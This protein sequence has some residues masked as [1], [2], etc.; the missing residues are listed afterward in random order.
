MKR[1]H[2]LRK[3]TSLLLTT[4]LAVSVL[5]AAAAF[6]SSAAEVQMQTFG[7]ISEYEDFYQE[8][9]ELIDRIALGIYNMDASISVRDLT[10]PYPDTDIGKVLTIVNRIHPELFY[11]SG[12]S[13]T[14]YSSGGAKYLG[15][16]RP[17]YLY[18]NDEIAAMREEFYSRAQWFIDKVD[19][20]MSD[21]D[22]ALLLHDELALYGSYLLSGETYS[23]MVE[24]KGKCYGYSEVYAFL[25]A[26][27]GIKSEIIE[28]SAMN[29]QWNKVCIDGVY[30]HVDITWDDPVPD[31]PGFSKHTFFL[32]SDDAIQGMAEGDR[33]Y[34]YE[35]A[36]PS[37]NRFDNYS[38]HK[39]NTKL[40]KIGDG[41]Y[42]VDNNSGSA[43]QKELLIYD[44]DTDS[45]KTVK[46]FHSEYW[47]TASGG[48]WLGG[49]MALLEQDGY[50]YMNTPN[51]V[52]VYDTE[53]EEFTTF[54]ENTFDYSLYGLKIVDG[55]LYVALA[56][57]PNKERTLEYIGDCLVREKP[58]PEYTLGDVDDDGRVTIK[59][60]TQ[61][62][63]YLAEMIEFTPR[64]LLAANV[65]S[66][67][68]VTINDVTAIQMI[69]AEYYD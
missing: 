45:Y 12:M 28:S 60:A 2:L 48:Y 68:D 22:K 31:R 1:K 18:T 25:L 59:D 9:A 11:F 44:Y 23:F 15:E 35:T 57:T 39:I 61:I 67:D 6:P 58:L 41:Y 3:I 5:T 37:D 10:I 4:V 27:V 16:I 47:R 50:L 21:F 38:F 69:V 33:H 46:E 62:Q 54:Y 30:Y 40:C 24:G 7:Y 13:Y 63:R 34:G 49:Y 55:K 64:E 53:T 8:H 14:I 52:Y 17:R 66:K 32:L 26:Q 42:V 20:N 29:H 36:F 19:D 65:D 43:H 56:E 51:K